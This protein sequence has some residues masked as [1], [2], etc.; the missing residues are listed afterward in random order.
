MTCALTQA[1]SDVRNEINS[2]SPSTNRPKPVSGTWDK[3]TEAKRKFEAGAIKYRDEKHGWYICQ[4]INFHFLH[5]KDQ[6][7]MAN[8][9]SLTDNKLYFL[10]VLLGLD[11]ISIKQRFSS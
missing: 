1:R 7:H 10:S 11:E 2:T 5:Y 3:G 9:A 4:G 6:D 8:A